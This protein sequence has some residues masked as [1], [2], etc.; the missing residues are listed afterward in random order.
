MGEEKMTIEDLRPMIG[1][2]TNWRRITFR[3]AA[4]TWQQLGETFLPWKRAVRESM[5]S[6]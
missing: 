6:W 4:S 2:T 1:L 3:S 5:R